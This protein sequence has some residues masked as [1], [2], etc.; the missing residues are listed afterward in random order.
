M[1]LLNGLYSGTTYYV[2][3]ATQSGAAAMDNHIGT[4]MQQ[5]SGA[6]AIIG[7]FM[8]PTAFAQPGN[9]ATTVQKTVSKPTTN[10]GITPR[11]KKLLTYPY[12]FLG[13]DCLNDAKEYRYERFKTVNCVFNC[14]GSP[15]GNPS[16]VCAPFSYDVSN[17]ADHTQQIVMGGYPQCAFTVDSYRQWLAANG[18]FNVMT[19]IGSAI[20]VGTGLASTSPGAISLGLMGFGSA[21]AKDSV[22]K[23][24]ANTA[25]GP[26]NTNANVANRSKDIYFKKMGLLP[27]KVRAI[28]DFFDKYG[29]A[30]ERVKVPNIHARPVWSY[31]KTR[32]CIVKG[33]LPA[34]TAERIG[35][36]F[37]NGITFWTVGSVVGNYSQD[38]TV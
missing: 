20:P 22:E 8:C 32:D 37:D 4:Q 24:R 1:P 2:E 13:V 3:P 10:G 38:N 17:V 16:V 26:V 15:Q 31:V 23:F 11:N 35:R 18:V 29:Y 14:T 25:R 30:C 33:D 28:D 36:I 9:D 27:E 12:C 7:I 5:A 34:D 21:V 19:Q 6:D